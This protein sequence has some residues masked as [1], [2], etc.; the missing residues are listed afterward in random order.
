MSDTN[1][2]LDP[3]TGRTIAIDPPLPESEAPLM[4]NPVLMRGAAPRRAGSKTTLY[5]AGAAIA[6]IVLAGGAYLAVNGMH[7]GSALMTNADTTPPPAQDAAAT[8]ATPAP[9]ATPA[10]VVAAAEQPAAPVRLARVEQTPRAE[11]KAVRHAELRQA[12]RAAEDN[13]ADTAVTVTPSQV[14]PPSTV[15]TP[16]PAPAP[17]AAPVI[18]PPPAAQ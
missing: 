4:G 12:A 13:G 3:V 6:V 17:V 15:A 10:P 1:V 5:A 2:A 9:I 18:T 7:Q 8:P 14:A 16:I 11:V